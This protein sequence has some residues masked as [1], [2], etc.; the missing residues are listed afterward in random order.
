MTSITKWS[1]L[2]GAE[3]DPY[4]NALKMFDLRGEAST[5][6]LM[7]ML[8]LFTFTESSTLKHSHY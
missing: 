8:T 6:Y 2:K 4:P 3:T 5:W 7:V 1:S